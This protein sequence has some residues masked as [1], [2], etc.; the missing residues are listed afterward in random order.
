[1][2]YQG[3]TVVITGGVGGLGSAVVEAL[4]G[5][6]AICHVP[7]RGN[8]AD[9]QR[10]HKLLT[11]HPGI[12]LTDEATVDGFYR[13]IP[14]LWASIHVA[15]GFAFGPVA[16]AGKSVLTSQIEINLVTCY[17]CCRSAVNALTATPS[18]G[19]IV[20]VA[21]RPALEWRSGAGMAAYTASKAAV[22]A[23]TVAL[24]EEVVKDNVLVNAVA[25]SIMDTEAN[26]KAMPKADH[27]AWPKVEDVAQTILFLASPDNK[28]T[29]GAI[30]PVYGRV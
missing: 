12:D 2:D 15:G 19:R 5:A 6:G 27:A 30:V 14:D 26:R 24:A 1:M 7:H 17:L 9:G 11:L 10:E 16:T 13:Q 22:A 28:V 3:R 18:G 4:L 8:A 20:N 21:A 29:R 23:L 25:P